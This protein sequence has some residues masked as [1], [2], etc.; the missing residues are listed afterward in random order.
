VKWSVGAAN[1][2]GVAAFLAF[3]GRGPKQAKAGG[4]S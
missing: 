4:N 2:L 3:A 1:M